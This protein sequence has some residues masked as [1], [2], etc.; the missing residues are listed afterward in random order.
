M[1]ITT[2]KSDKHPVYA[3]KTNFQYGC[4]NDDCL[5]FGWRRATCKHK[6]WRATQKDAF[7]LF[8]VS[9]IKKPLQEN[10]KKKTSWRSPNIA[11]KKKATAAELYVRINEEVVHMYI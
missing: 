3:L 5:L 6:H 11:T 8:T 2:G 10:I 4:L 9:Q 1:R 7:N